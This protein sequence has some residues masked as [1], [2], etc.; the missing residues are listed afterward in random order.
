MKKLLVLLLVLIFTCSFF[1]SCKY[2]PED[3][4]NKINEVLGKTPDEGT[5]DENPE[6]K[7]EE[8]PEEKPEDKPAHVHEFTVESSKDATCTTAGRKVV[9]C[10]CGYRELQPGDDALGHDMVPNMDDTPRCTKDITVT[11]QCSRCDEKEEKVIAAVGHNL[12]VE[13]EVSRIR[14]CQA[15]NCSYAAMPKGNGQYKDTIVYK[16]TED[17]LAE[18]DRIYDEVAA[19]LEEAEAYDATKHAYAEEGELHDKY[20]AL[21]AKYE[22]LYD[23]LLYVTT[24]YQIAQLEYHI[25]MA[26]NPAKEEAFDYISGVRTD[27]ISRFYEFSD[28]IYKSM[29]REFYYYGMTEQEINA[30]ILDSNAVSN[31]EYKALVD[32]NTA[33][34]IEYNA[35]PHP[36]V[37]IKVPGLYARFVANNKRIAE[38]L[39]YENYLEYAYENIYSREYSYEDVHQISDYVKKYISGNFTKLYSAW[40][41]MG[42][43]NE[44]DIDSYN[45][46]MLES[47]FSNVNS[48][49]T[50]NDYIDLVAFTSNPDKQ[51]TF[52]DSFN[53]LI[54]DGNLFRG[55]YEGAYVTYL[56]DLEL[57]IAYF[58]FDNSDPFTVAH[59]F[60]HY[61]NEI[62]N[63]NEYDQSYDLLEMHSQ[64]NELLYL[65]Y[66][67]ENGGMTD[68]GFKLCE[69]NQILNITFIIMSGLA[70][71]TFEQAL[72]TDE[73]TGTYADEIM[74]D[75]TISAN[76]YDKLYLGILTDFGVEKYLSGSYWRYVTIN[77]PCYY[78]SYSVSAISVLQLYDVA[79]W[80]GLD[81]AK[82][83]YLKLFTYTDENPDMTTEEILEYAGLYSYTDEELYKILSKL[84]ARS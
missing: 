39:G 41:S 33:I 20:L 73:Y 59:E 54:G 5:T 35:L 61:M 43:Y 56:V 51:I 58:G 1:A 36:D 70:V 81:A 83:A 15:K 2:L 26:S 19:L 50:L 7:P 21:E 45:S 77:S 27:L 63:D 42:G 37:D 28:P 9:V 64:G 3:V 71:D 24:Q 68:M 22:E 6:D 34:E 84:I 4:Q 11:Y 74:A 79:H 49:K 53:G 62:Y 16:F 76:E 44:D 48:N 18:F 47:F 75:G 10:S 40:N 82:D 12:S 57:P 23:V 66:L 69:R 55:R 14:V 80:N 67:K 38:I 32:D 13:V 30:F 25:A 8:K 17:D 72:Y 52:S 60:G 65:H 29:Y 46:Q 31:P 78:V